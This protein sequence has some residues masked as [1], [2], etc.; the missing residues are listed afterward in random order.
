M[1]EDTEVI[2]EDGKAIL[3]TGL[4]ETGILLSDQKYLIYDRTHNLKFTADKRKIYIRDMEACLLSIT[5]VSLAQQEHAKT[6]EKKYSQMTLATITHDLK[7]PITAIQ[8]NLQLLKHYVSSEGMKFLN[9]AQITASAF[10]YYLYDIT[11]LF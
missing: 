2:S 4:L 10:E 3:W 1:L 5:P 7:T 11:V 8:G 9:A 6:T